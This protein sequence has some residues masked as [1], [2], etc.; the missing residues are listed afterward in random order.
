MSRSNIGVP[1]PES[2]SM[3]S[4]TTAPASSKTKNVGQIR[5]Y[6]SFYRLIITPDKDGLAPSYLG[7]R[8]VVES[9][10]PFFGDA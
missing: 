10:K 4:S 3:I 6:D 8:M 7:S 1:V 2:P 9:I 5:E